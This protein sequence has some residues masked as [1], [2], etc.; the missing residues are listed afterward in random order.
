MKERGRGV[1]HLY[2]LA[3][4]DGSLYTG[5]TNDLMRRIEMHGK[6]TASKYTRSRR[7]VRMI[8]E[9]A[10]KSRSDALKKEALV[11]GMTRSKKE[12]YVRSHGEGAD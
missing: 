12:E 7:P 10:C 4:R 5:V 6:G 1:W 2:I 3:C 9:E 8:Y 11:K